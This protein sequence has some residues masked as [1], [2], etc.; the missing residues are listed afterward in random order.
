[1]DKNEAIIIAKKYIDFVSKKYKIQS[2]IL[3]GSYAK[4]T[5]R[6]D[7]D[8]DIAIVLKNVKDIIDTQIE[9]MKLRRQFDLRIEPHPFSYSEFNRTNPVVNEILKF[10]INIDLKA[11]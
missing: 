11:A 8:I 3:F 6:E 5:N 10:G 9:L 7:S 2:A 4:G 1:M